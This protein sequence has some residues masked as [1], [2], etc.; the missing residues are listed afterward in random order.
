M[1]EASVAVYAAV[2]GVGILLA[3]LAFIL[4]QKRPHGSEE[5]IGEEKTA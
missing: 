1:A 2:I 5:V 4:R 3:G